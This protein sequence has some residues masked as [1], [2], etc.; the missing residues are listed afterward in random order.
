MGPLL[1]NLVFLDRT[2]ERSEVM[3]PRRRPVHTRLTEQVEP[4]TIRWNTTAAAT[5]AREA[6]VKL[7]VMEFQPLCRVLPTAT[8]SPETPCLQLAQDT[9]VHPHLQPLTR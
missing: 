7:H 4:Q 2:M 9:S 8:I 1:C 5:R 3:Q 6:A